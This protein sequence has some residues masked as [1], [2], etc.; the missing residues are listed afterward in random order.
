MIGSILAPFPQIS[1]LKSQISNCF[2]DIL[3]QA[4][5]LARVRAP[6]ARL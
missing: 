1:I 3:A 2:V 4:T 6:E 5:D